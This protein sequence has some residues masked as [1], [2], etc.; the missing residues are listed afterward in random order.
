MNTLRR[1][2][3]K[4]GSEGARK[5]NPIHP[6]RRSIGGDQSD[7]S[8]NTSINTLLVIWKRGKTEETI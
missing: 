2:A 6:Y 3:E 4:K 8:N 7:Q 1:W 5:P